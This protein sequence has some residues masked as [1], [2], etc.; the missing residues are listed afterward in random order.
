MSALK[1]EV[2][3]EFSAACET[4]SSD[5]SA[6]QREE[7]A[8]YVTAMHVACVQ[9]LT[10]YAVRG[11]DLRAVLTSDFDV[12]VQKL[13]IRGLSDEETAEAG[14]FSAERLGGTVM[15]KCFAPRG[16][17]EQYT[18]VVSDVMWSDDFLGK[19]APRW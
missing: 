11:F 13:A 14:R 10:H 17:E 16:D 12:L 15:A 1:D 18:I 19:E 8:F 2:T 4:D 7:F 3:P 5:P 6:S 9:V